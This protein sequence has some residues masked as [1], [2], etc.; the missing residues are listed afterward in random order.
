MD[1]S[2]FPLPLPDLQA[3]PEAWSVPAIGRSEG[4]TPQAHL[5]DDALARSLFQR[6]RNMARH[7]LRDAARELC[8]VA[9]LTHQPLIA[10]DEELRRT[11]FA[12]LITAHGFKLLER[13]VRATSG[14]PTHIIVTDDD[15]L[16]AT[17][18]RRQEQSGVTTYTIRRDRLVLLSHEDPLTQRWSADLAT[19]TIANADFD[20]L[21]NP[22]AATNNAAAPW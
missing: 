4:T 1:S 3:S 18:R 17:L 7:H 8:A 12:A 14:Q 16:P 19:G 5:S 9:I 15:T 11:A 2:G 20:A 10:A 13:T 6:A 21:G 22:V